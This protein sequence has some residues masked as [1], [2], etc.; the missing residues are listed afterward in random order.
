MSPALDTEYIA[1]VKSD[2]GIM[3]KSKQEV[4]VENAVKNVP[5]IV[6]KPKQEVLAKSAAQIV[7]EQRGK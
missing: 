2:S 3:L 5:G 7:H 1:E 6:L 4:G